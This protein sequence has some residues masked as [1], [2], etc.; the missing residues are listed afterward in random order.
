MQRRVSS[1]AFMQNLGA[2]GAESKKKPDMR[3]P[4]LRQPLSESMKANAA[5]INLNALNPKKSSVPPP[6]QERIEEIEEE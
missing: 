2:F 6:V 3:K 5:K 1:A 4:N